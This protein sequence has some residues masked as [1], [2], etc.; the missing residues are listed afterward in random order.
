MFSLP[1][2]NSLGFHN[3]KSSCFFSDVHDFP[4]AIYFR[5]TLFLLLIWMLL[6]SKFLLV[7]HFS[8]CSHSISIPTDTQGFNSQLFYQEFPNLW[9]FSLLW[10]PNLYVKSIEIDTVMPRTFLKLKIKIRAT[11]LFHCSLHQ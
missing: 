6:S 9:L 1:S 8:F 5:A 7:S 4:T 10:M 2:W 11:F 3:T